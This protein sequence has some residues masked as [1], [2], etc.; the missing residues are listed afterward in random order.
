MSNY[1][2]NANPALVKQII[3]NAKKPTKSTWRNI[4]TH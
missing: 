2:I 3:E 1:D 4:R